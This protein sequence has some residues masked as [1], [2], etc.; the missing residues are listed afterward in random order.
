VSIGAWGVVVVL[1]LILTGN[2]SQGQAT[3]YSTI[4]ASDVVLWLFNVSLVCFFSF[5][6]REDT[7]GNGQSENPT[8]Q[9]HSITLS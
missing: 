8:K 2:F 3:L 6:L 1:T 7:T 4:I 9:E 5:R